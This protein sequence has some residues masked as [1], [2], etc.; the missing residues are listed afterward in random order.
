MFKYFNKPSFSIWSWRWHLRLLASC[1]PRCFT[2]PKPHI[3]I[4]TP[5]LLAIVKIQN[6]PKKQ[7]S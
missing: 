6:L 5:L 7:Q 2:F 4:L 1:K 3:A